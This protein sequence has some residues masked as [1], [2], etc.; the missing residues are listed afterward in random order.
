MSDSTSNRT[1]QVRKAIPRQP[2]QSNPPKLSLFD[3]LFP[4]ERESGNDGG[5]V[6]VDKLPP[7][8]FDQSLEKKTRRVRDRPP[9]VWKSP[10]SKHNSTG[11][12]PSRT[13]QTKQED[14][15]QMLDAAVLI[16]NSAC[17]RLEESDF[18][19]IGHKG[20]HIQGWTTGIIKG[21]DTIRDGLSS[22]VIPVLT[23]VYSH[24]GS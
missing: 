5:E 11:E 22:Q 15:K 20:A 18:L 10:G 13:G 7:F 6:K 23:M 3:E 19:R 21:T 24:S 8:Q 9:L 14:E 12:L 2:K 1:F 4:E 16:L 17:K